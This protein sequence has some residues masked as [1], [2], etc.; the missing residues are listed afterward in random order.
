MLNERY[1]LQEVISSR[2]DLGDYGKRSG[3]RPNLQTSL[4]SRV[5]MTAAEAATTRR[6]M[7]AKARMVIEMDERIN[8]RL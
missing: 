3:L 7:V 5:F 6:G 1:I 8:E 2:L 4:L